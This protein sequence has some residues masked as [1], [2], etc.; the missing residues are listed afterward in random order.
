[1]DKD[2]VLIEKLLIS[3][4]FVIKLCFLKL[5]R[6]ILDL[7]NFVIDIRRGCFKVLIMRLLLIILRIVFGLVVFVGNLYVI[8][9]VVIMINFLVEV[10]SL[11]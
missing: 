9:V 10:K 5:Y 4:S 2:E 11:V 6:G 3:L 8:F 1:M 7:F